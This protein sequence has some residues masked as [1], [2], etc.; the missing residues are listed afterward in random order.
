MIC[1]DIPSGISVFLDEN[2]LVYHFAADPALG[3]ACRQLLTRIAKKEIQGFAST[4]VLCDVAHRVMTLEAISLFGWPATSI[5]VRLRKHHAE[6]PRLGLYRRAIAEVSQFGIQ[7]L[8][9]PDGLVATAG[10]ICQQ[11]E[12]LMGDALIVAVMQ[13]HGLTHLASRDA[14]FDRVPGIT[15]Y[16]PV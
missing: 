14:D 3:P 15:R 11:F 10:S 8:P 4:H 1:A 9:I 7:V 5:A 13:H 16:A 12:L 2:T 6:I